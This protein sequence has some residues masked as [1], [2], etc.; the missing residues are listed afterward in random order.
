MSRGPWTKP[1][2]CLRMERGETQR[3][4]EYCRKCRANRINPA[5]YRERQAS[6]RCGSEVL[7]APGGAEG[8]RVA[9]STGLEVR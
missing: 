3:P 9:P 5:N 2:R 8:N 6:R 1:V 4:C 7:A